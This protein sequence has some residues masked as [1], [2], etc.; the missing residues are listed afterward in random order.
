MTQLEN[1]NMLRALT[2]KAPL[3]VFTLPVKM[4]N[5]RG[6]LKNIN[7]YVLAYTERQAHKLMKEDIQ[8]NGFKPGIIKWTHRKEKFKDITKRS[9]KLEQENSF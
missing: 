3:V 9:S 4:R 1:Y 8:S 6:N 7:L 5:N 2:D